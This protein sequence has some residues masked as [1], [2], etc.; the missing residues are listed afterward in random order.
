MGQARTADQHVRRV[1]MI[2][3]RQD[4]PL[5]QQIGIVMADAQPQALHLLFKARARFNRRQCQVANSARV[6]HFTDQAVVDHTDTAFAVTQFELNQTHEFSPVK[7]NFK[8]PQNQ[9]GS[10]LAR[11]EAVIPDI[12]S[13]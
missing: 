5:R 13:D 9:C 6:L 7:Q 11:E 8:S 4:A 10:G 3:R 12:T 2:Q 1:R